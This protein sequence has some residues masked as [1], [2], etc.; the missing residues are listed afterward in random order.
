[1]PRTARASAGGVCYHVLNRGNR[2]ER[3]FHDAADYRAFIDQIGRARER[4][5]LGL[6]AFCVMPNH[7][8][9]VVI[10][11]SDDDLG[12]WMQWL[13]TVHV[14]RHHRV[15]GTEGRV[16]QGRYKSFPVQTDGY[17]RRL[18]RYVERNP[19]RASLVDRAERWPWSSL[20]WSEERRCAALGAYVP[21]AVARDWRKR[22]NQ[23]ETRAELAAIRA[24]VRRNRPFGRRPWQRRVAAALGLEASMNPVG[25]PPGKGR[26]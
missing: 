3:V 20:A 23:P 10:P 13:A 4:L 11:E 15:H 12:R 2:R 6:L 24:C 9:L 16:W 5:P 26:G 8:H 18:V 21:E 25:R 19:V 17:L 14:R 22:V 7:F 1:M